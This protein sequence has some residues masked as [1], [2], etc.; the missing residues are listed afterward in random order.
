[1]F[2]YLKS[3][4]KL[5]QE[6]KMLIEENLKL[7]EHIK[8]SERYEKCLAEELFRYKYEVYNLKQKLE[9]TTVESKTASNI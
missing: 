8:A 6:K 4:A 5:H 9:A 2:D 3:K 1:M 7:Q